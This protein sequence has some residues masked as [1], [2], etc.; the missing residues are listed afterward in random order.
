MKN[1]KL[2]PLSVF[3]GMAL[4]SASFA[5]QA[6]CLDTTKSYENK[7][8][9]QGKK[10]NIVILSQGDCINVSSGNA[11]EITKN[12]SKQNQGSIFVK[13]DLTASSGVA[14]LLDDTTNLSSA[15]FIGAKDGGLK[16]ASLTPVTISGK[17]GLEF[18]GEFNGYAGYDIKNNH[19]IYL[20]EGSKI[21]GSENAIKIKK[22]QKTLGRNRPLFI[23]VSG[24]SIDGNIEV[25]PYKSVTGAQPITSP[26][27]NRSQNSEK[28]GVRLY[29]YKGIKDANAE[30]RL[31]SHSIT[32]INEIGNLDGNLVIVSD[33]K[34][35]NWNTAEFLS[36]AD[37]KLSF[38]TNLETANVAPLVTVAKADVRNKEV[39]VKF[40]D[41]ADADVHNNAVALSGRDKLTFTLFAGEIVSLAENAVKLFDKNGNS[42]EID[43]IS[44]AFNNHQYMT[45]VKNGSTITSKVEGNA[46]KV[47][48]T[49][50]GAS[51]LDIVA[52]V[53]NTAKIDSTVLSEINA[54]NG[55]KSINNTGD[56]EI[57]LANSGKIDWG[58]LTFNS[59]GA[60]NTLVLNVAGVDQNTSA[61]FSESLLSVA[62][63]N[64]ENTALTLKLGNYTYDENTSGSVLQGFDKVKL[65][66]LAD[67]ENSTVGLATI[68]V[69]DKDGQS[70][71]DLKET[72]LAE[73]I[74][75]THK[76]GAL[77]L[78]AQDYSLN[79][80]AEIYELTL[81]NT[82]SGG[83]PRLT[84]DIQA[85]IEGKNYIA[86]TNKGD[87][88]IDVANSGVDLGNA[89]FSSANPDSTL[90]LAVE[91][92]ATSNPL[93]KAGSVNV[94]NQKLLVQ[95]AEGVTTQDITDKD[96]TLFSTGNGVTVGDK[97]E[98]D[99]V[100]NQGNSLLQKEDKVYTEP[101]S[102]QVYNQKAGE[103]QKESQANQYVVR[104]KAGAVEFLRDPSRNAFVSL[105]PEDQQ[106]F[107]SYILDEKFNGSDNEAEQIIRS[108]RTNEQARR[109]ANQMMPDLSA[110]DITAA[111]VWGEQM[112]S[113]IEQRTLA[114]R[115]QLPSYEREDGWNLW[116]TTSLGRGKD[117]GE[118]KLNRYGVHFGM[119]RQ[120]NDE[121]LI[122]FS[123]G[124]NR[125]SLA[126]ERSDIDKKV[127]QFIFMPYVEWKGDLYFAEANLLGGTYSVDSTRQIGNTTAT[128]D[129]SGFQFGY[130]LTGGID[131]E[132]KGV[133]LRPFLSLKQQWFN[134]EGWEETGS[135]FALSADTQKYSAQHIGGG[136]SLWKRFDLAIGKFVPSLDLQYYKQM[137]GSDATMSYRLASDSATTGY[138]FNVNNITGNQFSTKLNARLDITEN[139]NIS[140]SLSYNKFGNYKETVVG[141]G[142]SNTF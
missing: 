25:N 44:T 24:G 100:D 79:Y 85:Q 5:A 106:P 128:G 139:L 109:L 57:S 115:H 58:N 111:W 34:G 136:I 107:V 78:S 20:L 135:P 42:L 48:Y 12:N 87:A 130:Q 61:S 33:Q 17:I 10:A 142:L 72:T 140:G 108:A 112:R 118:Y 105:L 11:V 45:L 14:L 7:L 127:T 125:S 94:A 9:D 104:Y 3:V 27:E 101:D 132:V 122:G 37:S 63:A 74:V 13:N 53:G 69:L 95:F 119:D 64:I 35:D 46:Y 120:I 52:D 59:G 23:K 98:I 2:L 93:L 18:D 83:V 21:V 1:L 16:P 81:D 56:L 54:V 86:V 19:G 67:A 97:T 22:E 30:S 39:K 73:N 138:D 15:L 102:W 114:Y 29:V 113:H 8:F 75:S 80:E 65:L 103:L 60:D 88:V 36:L 32:G 41:L 62:K 92:Q 99:L 84:K 91:D 76:N 137:G 134:N 71:S 96:Y 6:A 77:T 50:D 117:S 123:A 121:A 124:V 131:T 4:Y 47:T 51:R 90:T 49:Y 26:I 28:L 110:S 66:D 133:G 55:L 82:A 40:T 38:E 68:K 70:L 43:E 126:S 89:T 31:R 141:F 129:Y 116:A